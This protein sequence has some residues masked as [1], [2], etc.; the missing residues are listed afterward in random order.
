MEQLNATQQF[1]G[2]ETQWPAA[3]VELYDVQGLWGGRRIY[4]EGTKRVVAQLV[5]P[6]MRERRYEFALRQDDLKR[7]LDLFVENDFLTIRPPERAG[8]P[9]EARPSIRL[10]NEDGDEREVAK[11]AG[12]TD[13]RFDRLYQALLRLEALAQEGEPVYR[14]PYALGV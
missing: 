4:V 9:D 6:T 14:G 13:E 10:V 11:W 1:L 3:R 5:E 8:I 7:L 2:D 12:V